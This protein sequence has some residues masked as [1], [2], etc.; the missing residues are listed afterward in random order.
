MLLAAALSSTA[1]AHEVRL[2]DLVLTDLWAR[3][4]PPKAPTGAGYLTIAN[5]GAAPDALIA[6]ASPRAGRAELHRMETKDGVMVMRPVAGGLEIPA[7]GTVTLAPGGLHIMFSDL[8]GAF[9]EG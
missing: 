8:N 6:V 2:G 4:T 1:L 7:G 9:V 5:T 3:A